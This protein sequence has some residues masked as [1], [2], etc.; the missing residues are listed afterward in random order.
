MTDVP[1]KM[2]VITIYNL[3]ENFKINGSL[4]RRGIRELVSKGSIVPVA[5]SGTMCVYTRSAKAA[6][7]AKTDEAKAAATAKPSKGQKK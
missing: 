6:A 5:P 2:K 1:K 4:A 7:S 3:V